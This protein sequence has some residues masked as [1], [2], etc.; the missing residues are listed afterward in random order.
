MALK[1]LAALALG[2][3]PVVL[4]SEE[5]G[6]TNVEIIQTSDYG[7][8]LVWNTV[9]PGNTNEMYLLNSNGRT[10]FA[11]CREAPPSDLIP[12]DIDCAVVLFE[13][14]QTSPWDNSI[15]DLATYTLGRNNKDPYE[16]DYQ[17]ISLYESPEFS[18]GPAVYGSNLTVM[19]DDDSTGRHFLSFRYRA[20]VV[21]S[22]LIDGDWVD[23]EW[24]TST[25]SLITPRECQEKR[26]LGVHLRDFEFPLDAYP[27][28]VTVTITVIDEATSAAFNT[29]QEV[30]VRNTPGSFSLL[31]SGYVPVNEESGYVELAWSLHD[32]LTGENATSY[33]LKYTRMA[34]LGDSSTESGVFA[35][36]SGS[37]T[38]VEDDYQGQTVPMNKFQ[39]T[40]S[41]T[42]GYTF[43]VRIVAF[44]DYGSTSTESALIAVGTKPSPVQDHKYVVIDTGDADNALVETTW[45][46]PCY[47]GT[48]DR[49]VFYRVLQ[50]G[51]VVKQQNE[52]SASLWVPHN[53]TFLLSVRAVNFIGFY[54]ES[55]FSVDTADVDVRIQLSTSVITYINAS[56][57]NTLTMKFE[58]IEYA[59][60]YVARVRPVGV[61]AW[62]SQ[63]VSPTEGDDIAAEFSDLAPGKY[64]VQVAGVRLGQIGDFSAD[65]FQNVHAVPLSV[66]G[67]ESQIDSELNF[68][69]IFWDGCEGDAEAAEVQWRDTTLDLPAQTLTTRESFVRVP[70][71][72]DAEH[73]YAVRVRCL[74]PVGLSA[75]TEWGFV[76]KET[77]DPDDVRVIKPENQVETP[78]KPSND[79]F[80]LVTL[81]VV[82]SLLCCVGPVMYFTRR[83]FKM[84]RNEKAD[85]E[86]NDWELENEAIVFEETEMEAE[87]QL[88]EATDANHAIEVREYADE[89][90]PGD[91]H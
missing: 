61:E 89:E 48:V 54:D 9:P 26:N 43:D 86:L 60:K 21:E 90:S 20:K 36:P 13:D 47:S 82:L 81:L 4:G 37:I 73:E 88:E 80:L 72:Y 11:N 24:T 38:L 58:P 16:F 56:A 31:Q 39:G 3:F 62:R 69:F 1:L 6:F 30:Q 75:W 33:V 35:L 12:A 67:L 55:S 64:Q 87:I 22:R 68:L 83:Y 17:A 77:L 85:M 18:F 53:S 25:S 7:R 70:G 40:L 59:E 10:D 76:T 65:V 5:L 19:L 42:H 32:N 45:L 49:P 51:V 8:V 34:D 74:N 15:Y 23:S 29:T 44:N 27:M 28:K 41:L 2:F 79:N 91:S 46:A 78:A 66:E 57:P 84:K 50:D 52:T 63:F 71:A 14:D